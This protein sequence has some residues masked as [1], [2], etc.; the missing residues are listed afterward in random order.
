MVIK[1]TISWYENL[2]DLKEEVREQ[3]EKWEA[4]RMRNEGRFKK[5]LEIA[6]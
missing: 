1:S 2:E 3:K 6:I 5:K 4:K